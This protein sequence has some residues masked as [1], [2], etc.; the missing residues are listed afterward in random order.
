MY[1]EVP[2]I[3]FPNFLTKKLD[4]SNEKTLLTFKDKKLKI[5]K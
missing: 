2:G 5:E 1:Y 4:F 3:K